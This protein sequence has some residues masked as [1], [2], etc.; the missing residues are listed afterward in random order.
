M[1]AATISTRC[2]S[3]ISATRRSRSK[4][5][6][7]TQL[8]L[9]RREQR[10]GTGRPPTIFPPCRTSACCSRSSR[11]QNMGTHAGVRVQHP[12]RQIQGSAGAPRLQFRVRFRGDEQAAVLRPVHADR[13]LFRWHRAG[14]E[15]A[16]GRR[17]AASTARRRDWSSKSSRPCATRCRRRCSRPPTP[18]RSA[19]AREGARQSARGDAA[20]D[21]RPATR[22]ATEAGQRQDR[23]AASPSRLLAGGSSPTSG[24]SLFSSRRSSGSAST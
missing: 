6:R 20:V 5:S 1:S 24:S 18:I 11:V 14:L 9:A 2:G 19:A 22:C 16:R 4:R 15:C 8:D 7:A 23:R 12:A 10:Q 17:E 21:A 13:Q 3:N